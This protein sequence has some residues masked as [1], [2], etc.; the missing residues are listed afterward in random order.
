[1]DCARRIQLMGSLAIS[2]YGAIQLAYCIA[3]RQNG[4]LRFHK[5]SW[6]VAFPPG[7]QGAIVLLACEKAGQTTIEKARRRNTPA[8]NSSNRIPTIL[9]AGTKING[10]PQV[11]VFTIPQRLGTG[12]CVVRP[13]HEHSI[14]QLKTAPFSCRP[15]VTYSLL[16]CLKDF[17]SILPQCSISKASCMHY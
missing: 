1:M 12:G 7:K 15:H 16:L 3:S 10:S 14:S 6:H 17:G 13:F 9:Q 5:A 4:I 11:C 2:L 8:M